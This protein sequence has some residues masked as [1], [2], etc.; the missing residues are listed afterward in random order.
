MS[1]FNKYARKADEIAKAAFDEYRKAEAAYKKAEEQAR[2]Y[3]QRNGVPTDA[4]YM[5]KSARAQAD[6][7][8][9]REALK[10][11]KRVFADHASEFR[12][13][14]KELAA[15]IED[16]YSADPA[17]LDGNTLELLK[18][19]IM[20]GS[21]YA[22]LLNA[23]QAAGNATMVRMI[24]KYA[25]DAARDRSEKYGQH[26]QDASTMRMVEYQSRAYTGS[27]HLQAFD[28]MTEIYN[29]CAN[30]PGM[31]DHWGELTA[32]TVDSF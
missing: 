12:A 16:A 1:R 6:L 26:D 7:I 17:Q 27:D 18:S 5:A 24:G 22:K 10:H 9:A 8:E 11:A 3:P 4:A 21:E 28:N 30:N 13:I 29:R 2:Q 31:I 32:E 25:G 15:E 19:G 23:A 20:T 14:R